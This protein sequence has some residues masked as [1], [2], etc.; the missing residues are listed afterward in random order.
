MEKFTSFGMKKSLALPSLAVKIFNSV[1]DEN[2][3][4][5]YTYTDP[6]MRNFV[7]QNM[8]GGTFSAVNQYCKSSF[9]D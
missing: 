2:D 6:L 1:R 3:E 5:I 8:R 9:S 7:R 4:P